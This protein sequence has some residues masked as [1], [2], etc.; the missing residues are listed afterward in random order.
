MTL[1]HNPRGTPLPDGHPLKGGCVIFGQKR[2]GSS[3]KP[4]TPI[5]EPSTNLEEDNSFDTAAHKSLEE[6]LQRMFDPNMEHQWMEPN[7]SSESD[8]EKQPEAGPTEE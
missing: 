6:S 7:P 5:A 8:T 4:S 1:I 3:A 2:P